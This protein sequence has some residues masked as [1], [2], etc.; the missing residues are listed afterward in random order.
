M[1]P[2]VGH[3]VHLALGYT[4]MRKGLD[5]LTVLVQKVLKKD[6][7]SG[8]LFVFRGKRSQILKILMAQAPLPVSATIDALG[9][10]NSPWTCPLVGELRC[11]LKQQN[12]PVTSL[13]S[14]ARRCKVALQNIAFL[15]PFIGKEAI[16]RLGVGP[17]LAGKRN[18]SAHPIT[19]PFKQISKPASQ[20]SILECSLIDFVFTPVRAATSEF[21]AS[22]AH[23][24]PLHPNQV[25]QQNHK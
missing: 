3:K 20:T 21:V 2:D 10:P 5:G 11:V 18:R 13:I 6:A 1:R 24:A 16:S 8:Q 15:N 23:F 12:R 22:H 14:H 4:D 17:I 19:E 7:F 9:E 25:P